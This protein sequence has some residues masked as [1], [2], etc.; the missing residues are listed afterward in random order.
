MMEMMITLS[1]KVRGQVYMLWIGK[2]THNTPG[3]SKN[4][5][6]I[7]FLLDIFNDRIMKIRIVNRQAS[8][9]SDRPELT[10]YTIPQ[11]RQTKSAELVCHAYCHQLVTGLQWKIMKNIFVRYAATQNTA[12]HL[13]TIDSV[14]CWLQRW[15]KK[16]RPERRQ[17]N[18]ADV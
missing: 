13:I 18:R 9:T 17:M 7:F 1:N 6:W 12:A 11:E 10:E 3:N 5:S 15:W 4:D 2:M 16:A 8:Q 14:L